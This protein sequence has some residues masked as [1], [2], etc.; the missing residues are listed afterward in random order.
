MMGSEGDHAALNCP[1]AP[2]AWCLGMSISRRFISDA[3]R[4]L[5]V[6]STAYS[7][8]LIVTND[9]VMFACLEAPIVMVWESE[10]RAAEEER[11]RIRRGRGT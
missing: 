2:F 3:W 1:H 5:I 6:L 11:G 10:A 8:S 7:A 4:V 9:L